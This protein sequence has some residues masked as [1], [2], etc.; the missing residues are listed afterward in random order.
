MDPVALREKLVEIFPELVQWFATSDFRLDD[1]YSLTYCGAFMECSHFV[2]ERLDQLRPA[3]LERIATF[4]SECM[5][6]PGTDLDDA[7]ATCFLENLSHE[8]AAD[9][10]MPYLYGEAAAYLRGFYAE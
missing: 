3:E 5:E 8:P 10:L 9:A 1:D 6:T 7:A 4:V 2:R